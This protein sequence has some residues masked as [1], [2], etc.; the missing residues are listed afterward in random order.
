[1][2]KSGAKASFPVILLLA[3]IIFSGLTGKFQEVRAGQNRPIVSAAANA[4]VSLDTLRKKLDKATNDQELRTVVDEFSTLPGPNAAASQILLDY[5]K[6][7]NINDYN[8]TDVLIKLM[9]DV[10]VSHLAREINTYDA[11]NCDRY[12]IPVLIAR[13]KNT[14]DLTSTLLSLQENY[15]FGNYQQLMEQNWQKIF[16]DTTEAVPWLDTVYTKLANPMARQIFIQSVGA[17]AR[18]Q[19]AEEGRSAVTG[20]LWRIQE[21]ES[22]STDRYDQVLTLYGLGETKSLEAIDSLYSGIV[23][24][25]E[26]ANL[27]RRVADFAH[28]LPEGAVKKG[29]VDWLW[30]VAGK[31][32]S[33]YCR[34]AALSALYIDLG[35]EKALEQYVWETDLNGMAVAP[36]A[37]ENPVFRVGGTD[38]RLLKDA[39]QKYPQSYL[40]SGIKAYEEV[41]GQ[42]YFEIDRPEEQYDAVWISSYGDEEYNPDREIPG[43]EKFLVEFPRHPATD[44]AAYRLARCYEIKGR[45]AD[46]V[47]TLQKARFLPDGDMNYAAGGRLVYILDVK[48]TYDQLKALSLNKLERPLNAYVDY[49]LAVKEI[50]RD[51]FQ[52]ASSSLE[53]FLKQKADPAGKYVFPFDLYNVDKYDFR[54]AVEKQLADAKKL[55]GLKSQWEASKAPVDSYNLAAAIYHNEMLYYNHLWAGERQYYNW[56]GYINDTGYG[57]A[58]AEMADFAREMINYNHSL[59]YFQRVDQDQSSAP[60]LKARALYSTGLCYIGLDEWGNDASFAFNP[61]EIREKVISTYQQFAERYPDSTMADDAL[62]A[63]GAYTGDA[64]YLQKL[65]KEYPASDVMEK[66]KNLIEDMKSPYYT[67]VSQYGWSVPF[68]FLSPNDESIP[69]E[70]K[71]WASANI[72]LSYTGSK[73]SGKWSYLLIAAGQKPTAGYSVK[74]NSIYGEEDKLKI[75]YRIDGPAPG[76]VAAQVITCPYVLIRISAN[77]AAVEFVEGN[78]WET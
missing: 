18:K 59:P 60:E 68:K 54:G 19:P 31:E 2:H 51:D 73:T 36:L 47:K 9:T 1:M 23:S 50:R 17:V 72:P 41:R 56:L 65:I 26:K 15:F 77:K 74:V 28:W 67:P 3:I 63:L 76:Q 61:M 53:E 5:L 37:Q 57:H 49:S 55:N 21:K 52:Q 30:K 8:I 66:A 78:P 13:I 62:L 40:G 35:Q 10:Q 38:W 24:P 45:F 22:N 46:A 12:L 16:A 43:W 70:I 11:A 33:A 6:D 44:D 64:A 75:Y 20:W 14:A 48:M 69:Q 4:G 42:S 32:A 25:G 27:I 34:Q 39:C 58:P 29:L 7:K 71:N